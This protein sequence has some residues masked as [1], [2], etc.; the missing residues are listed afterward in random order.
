MKIEGVK[1]L[2]RDFIRNLFGYGFSKEFSIKRQMRG[3]TIVEMIVS[4]T[5]IGFVSLITLPTIIYQLASYDIEES[6]KEISS[7][8][9]VARVRA[10]ETHMPHRVKFDLNSNPQRFIIQRGTTSRGVITWVDDVTINEIRGNVMVNKIDD[11]KVSGKTSGIGSIEFSPMGSPTRGVVYLEDSKGE[12][13][14]IALNVSTGK[15]TKT[16]GW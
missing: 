15:V 5:V 16:K 3:F 4:L 8:F 14:T 2:I 12:R 1:S 9:M 13:Y 11:V 10:I 6:A 7:A